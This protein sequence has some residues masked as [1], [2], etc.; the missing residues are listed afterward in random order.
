MKKTL[1]VLLI[2]ALFLISGCGVDQQEQPTEPPLIEVQVP[3]ETAV[4]ELPY[5]DVEL[6]MQS[7]W[8]RED[9]QTRIMLEAAQLFE[10]Q[11][12]AVVTILWSGEQTVT[13]EEAT[14]VDIFQLCASD[15]SAMPKEYALDLTQMA[16]EAQYEARSHEALRRQITEQCGYLGAVAQV[17]Y[18]GGIYYNTEIF[19]QCGIDQ[20][21]QTWD[22]FLAVCQTLREAGWEPLTLDKEDA[23]VAM[24][25]HLRRTIG[26]AEMTRLMGKGGYWHYEQTVIAAMEQ[27]ALFVRD[28]NVAGNAPVDYPAGQNKMAMSNSAMMVGTN[29]DCADVEEAT[30]TDLNWGIF[31]Y[32]GSVSSGTW[33]TADVL[34]IHRDSSN[35]QA[36]FDFLMLLTTG[37]FDQLRADITGGI[38]ADPTN[39]SLIVGAM[40]TLDAAQ[41]ESLGIFGSRQLDAAVKLWSAWY[42]KAQSYATALE[43]SK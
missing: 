14:N 7:M 13:P 1:W 36:A 4:R 22:A 43:R 19:Q 25:L 8:Q 38:P 28:G 26:D 9:P 35:A 31:P 39:A 24:E 42:Q 41:P 12:G 16:Q 20:I 5:Q 29:A 40:D 33:M 34:M 11:T 3:Y 18:L 23:V 21:P 30:L 2:I 32:P 10:K 17:P 6:T 37:E 27:V 15:F